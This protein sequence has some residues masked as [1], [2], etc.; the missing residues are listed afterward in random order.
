MPTCSRRGQRREGGVFE[1]LRRRGPRQR[2][3]GWMGRGP[4]GGWSS[5]AGDPA[6]SPALTTSSPRRSSRR[7]PSRSSTRPMAGQRPGALRSVAVGVRAVLAAVA[8]AV[9]GASWTGGSG[10]PCGLWAR[11]A[12]LD[13]PLSFDGLPAASGATSVAGRPPWWNAMVDPGSASARARPRLA[14]RR[15]TCGPPGGAAWMAVPLRNGS[16]PPGFAR[17][18]RPR[19]PARSASSFSKFSSIPLSM[20]PSI[21]SR[22]GDGQ[23]HRHPRLGDSG[24]RAG[25]RTR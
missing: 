23:E 18:S 15:F 14:A 20:P 8:L 5:G 10:R 4:P 11:S 3:G 19:Q 6:G 25:P 17:R 2:D 7:R 22:F 1:L 9:P 24:H 12:S 16:V 13:I 21:A